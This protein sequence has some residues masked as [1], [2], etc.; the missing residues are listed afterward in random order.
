MTVKAFHEIPITVVAGYWR[1]M[2]LGRQ[3]IAWHTPPLFQV[4]ERGLYDA[5]TMIVFTTAGRAYHLADYTQFYR[6]M[7][8]DGF[9]LY[10]HENGKEERIWS[11]CVAHNAPELLIGAAPALPSNVLTFKR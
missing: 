2:G 3:P 7:S 6:V 10:V 9:L 11:V 8:R 1:D 4:P 5:R